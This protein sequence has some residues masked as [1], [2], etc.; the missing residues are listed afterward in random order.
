LASAYSSR[1]PEIAARLFFHLREVESVLNVVIGEA[2]IPLYAR[3]LFSAVETGGLAN[4]RRDVFARASTDAAIA[5]A[6]LA[7]E[8][9]GSAPWLGGYVEELLDSSHP[10]DQ[11]LGLTIAG[12]RHPNAGSDQQLNKEWGT[13]F[14]GTAAAA[15]RN[16]YE[17]A[18]WA[19]YWLLSARDSMDSIEFWRFAKLAEG[20][21]D[22]RALAD[23]RNLETCP[24]LT[25][26]GDT[27]LEELKRGAGERTKKRKETLFGSKVP[28]RDL[29]MALTGHQFQNV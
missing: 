29:E 14:L 3:A 11:A 7:A 18:N 21:S 1:N 23:F 16:S 2:R 24:F 12:F 17:R 13:G 15:A 4:L 27:L 26:Y 22:L 20:V 9:S 6:S 19:R 25:L 5:L 28:E 10:A 8:E